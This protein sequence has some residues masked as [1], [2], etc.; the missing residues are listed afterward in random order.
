MFECLCQSGWTGIHCETK[1]NYCEN[2]TCLN[3]GVCRPLLLNYT[4]ECL[5]TSYSGRHCETT[6]KKIIIYKIIAIS[7]SSVAIL[8]IAGAFIFILILDVLKYFFGMDL[9][10]DELERIQRKKQKKKKKVKPSPVIVRYIY[11]NAPAQ[12]PPRTTTTERDI[13]TIEETSV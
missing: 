6:E 13:S 2:V 8:Y 7:F 10:K 4:C 12:S 11:V 3:N 1:I 5:G 9:T